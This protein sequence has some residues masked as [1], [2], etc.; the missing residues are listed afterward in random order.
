M[1]EEL[2]RAIITE[3]HKPSQRFIDKT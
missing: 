2:K 3:W 1:V